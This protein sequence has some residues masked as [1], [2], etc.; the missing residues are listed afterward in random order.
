MA[1]GAL[2][3]VPDTTHRFH[4]RGYPGFHHD[5]ITLLVGYHQ[6]RYGF[7]ELGIGRNI[8]GVAHHPYGLGYHIGAEVRVDR[9]DIRGLKAGIHITGGVAMGVHFI[10]YMEGDHTMQV[11]RPEF[12]IGLFKGKLTYA[13]NWR[14]TKPVIDGINTHMV[15]FAYAFRL[16]R[17]PRDD[18]RQ[19]RP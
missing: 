8:Y 4:P 12:G 11:L 5:E 3:Q 19:G 15:S 16:K 14:L 7:A 18:V 13:Y 1:T 10:H 17:L 2:A 9:S 6:G